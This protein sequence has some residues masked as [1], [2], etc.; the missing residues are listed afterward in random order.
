MRHNLFSVHHVLLSGLFVGV[1]FLVQ[2]CGVVGPPIAPEDIGIEAKIRAQKQAEQEKALGPEENVI[3]LEQEDVPL[4]P[5]APLG[6][7]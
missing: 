6:S 4:P 3:P 2:S 1:G 7:Q 5:L